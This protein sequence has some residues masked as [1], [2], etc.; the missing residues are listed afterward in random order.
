MRE[1]LLYK[2]NAPVLR[3][4]VH[5]DHLIPGDILSLGFPALGFL[6]LGLPALGF[7]R[8]GLPVLTFQ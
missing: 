2:V 5:N 3:A 4:I 7:L 8:L 1:L 6:R